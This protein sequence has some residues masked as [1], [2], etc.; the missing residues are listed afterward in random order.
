M[1]VSSV[2]WIFWSLEL[3]EYEHVYSGRLQITINLPVYILLPRWLWFARAVIHLY[4]QNNYSVTPRHILKSHKLLCQNKIHI[5]MIKG[6]N[7]MR[8]PLRHWTKASKEKPHIPFLQYSQSVSLGGGI[9]SLS[10]LSQ[11]ARLNLNYEP[12][13]PDILKNWTHFLFENSTVQ[14]A[15]SYTELEES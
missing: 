11:K 14:F 9:S 6:H 7:S 3:D 1:V 15:A 12:R 2:N 8:S 4:T 13:L 10:R 5:H